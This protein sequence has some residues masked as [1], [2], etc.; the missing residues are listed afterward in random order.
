MAQ[1]WY[2]KPQVSPPES[3]FGYRT[4]QGELGKPSNNWDEGKGEGQ[5]KRLGIKEEK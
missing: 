4:V 5:Q 2:L 1:R 3:E